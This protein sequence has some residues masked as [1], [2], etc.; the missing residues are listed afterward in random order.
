MNKFAIRFYTLLLI[1]G[2][3]FYYVRYLSSNDAIVQEPTQI[4]VGKETKDNTD[5]ESSKEKKDYH[6]WDEEFWDKAVKAACMGA[7]DTDLKYT[8]KHEIE[9]IEVIAHW[10]EVSWDEVSYN[11]SFKAPSRDS[12]RYYHVLLDEELNARWSGSWGESI[13]QEAVAIKDCWEDK[14]YTFI[15]SHGIT[16]KYELEEIDAEEVVLEYEENWKVIEKKYVF[17]L[18]WNEILEKSSNSFV[19]EDEAIKIISKDSGVKKEIIKNADEDTWMYLMIFNWLDTKE[20]IY[21]YQ[22]TDKW[23]TYKYELDA[24]SWKIITKDVQKDI[25]E[26]WALDIAMK[27]AWLTEDSFWRPADWYMKSLV[28]PDIEKETLSW[29]ILYKVSIAAN[30]DKVYYYEISWSE[31]KITKSTI[32]ESFTIDKKS[33]TENNLTYTLSP[34]DKKSSKRTINPHELWIDD[35]YD[36]KDLIYLRL[37]FEWDKV[38]DWRIVDIKDEETLW[39]LSTDELFEEYYF[40]KKYN[41]ID[42]GHLTENDKIELSKLKEW[43]IYDYY[44]E[45]YCDHKI[46]NDLG[47]DIIVYWKEIWRHSYD[48]SKRFNKTT[49]LKND[50]YGSNYGWCWWR[51]GYTYSILYKTVSTEDILKVVRPYQIYYLSSLWNYNVW[52]EIDRDYNM[53]YIYNDTENNIKLKFFNDVYYRDSLD[54]WIIITL[55]PDEWADTNSVTTITIVGKDEVEWKIPSKPITKEIATK[56]INWE[57]NDNEIRKYKSI[58]VEWAQIL[59][60]YY[61]GNDLNLWGIESISAEAAA[62]LAKFK[63]DTLRLNSVKSLSAEAAQEIAKYKG[64]FMTLNWLETIDVGVAVWLAKYR[65]ELNP[66]DTDERAK[67][68]GP[69]L[70]LNWLKTISAEAATELAKSK[71]SHLSLEWLTDMDVSTAE[72]F[73]HYNWYYLFFKSLNKLTP[74]IVVALN[75]RDYLYLEWFSNIDIETAFALSKFSWEKIHLGITEIT[76]E[77][78]KA[79]A[80]FNGEELWLDSLTSIDAESA[81]WLSKYRGKVLRLM[82]LTKIDDNAAK[83]LANFKG[84]LDVTS[85]Y[86]IKEKIEKEKKTINNDSNINSQKVTNI[87]VWSDF[88]IESSEKIIHLSKYKKWQKFDVKPESDI[89]L[90]DTSNAMN[91]VIVHEQKDWN[92]TKREIIYI[93]PWEEY[94]VEDLTTFRIINL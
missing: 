64:A 50:Y 62:E 7:S 59:A 58:D 30:D 60:Q 43:V 93:G 8:C 23:Y 91:V 2:V 85:Y 56:Y 66:Y 36:Y 61:T 52:D 24:I 34:E 13:S 73:S 53:Y 31:W 75:S 12:F 55:H 18:R 69:I 26:K 20:Q 32:T 63:G 41:H 70:D 25:W 33:W 86:N 79:L 19:D 81:R 82:W 94:D 4:I 16:Y 42:S 88:S 74:E 87:N 47:K 90:N 40:D 48:D 51:E 1:W 46:I 29:Q 6:I 54:E 9:K 65:W 76:P 38:V 84:Q 14:I 17:E 72:A 15:Y 92:D 45:D 89:L 71:S 44:V 28:M 21:H 10:V 67:R 37:K 49:Y 57:I 22:F 83:E 68:F 27:E 3:W 35:I 77:V 11:V 5:K 78:A 39:K 80:R